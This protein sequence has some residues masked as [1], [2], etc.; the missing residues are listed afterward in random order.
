MARLKAALPPWVAYGIMPRFALAS[1]GVNRG[2]GDARR[3][4]PR[5]GGTPTKNGGASGE[6]RR[7]M[8]YDLASCAQYRSPPPRPPRPPP[9]PPPPPPP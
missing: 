5:S 8:N 4:A 6:R 7:R 2:P 9:R 1:A 3:G